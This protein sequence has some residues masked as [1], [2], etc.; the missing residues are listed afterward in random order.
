M[1]K[2][3]NTF[4]GLTK[5]TF[6]LAFTS[7]FADIAT[8]MLYPVLPVFLTQTLGANAEIVGLVEGVATATQNIVQ[9]FSGWLADRIQNRK[10]VAL[11]GYTLAALSKPV[12]G[13]ATAWQMVLFTRFSDRF[14]TGM[15]S[16]PRDALIAS[17][18]DANHRGKAFGLEGIGD[19]LGAF[20]GP[21]LAVVLLYTFHVNLR[22]IFFIAFIPG[23][24]AVSMILSV[25][26]KKITR[27]EGTAVKLT[28]KH[29]PVNYWKYIGVTA[30]F[31]L[32]NTSTSFLILQTRNLGIPLFETILIYAFFNL[33]AALIS[34]PAGSLSDK[35]GR[36]TILLGSFVIFL[37]TFLGFAVSKNVLVIGFLFVLYGMYQGI[38][39]ATGKALATDLVPQGLRASGIGWYATT[40]GIAS[41]IASIIGGQLWVL[42]NPHATFLYGAIFAILGIFGLLFFIH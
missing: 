41:L 28:L 24:F 12:F 1:N 22:T 25:N 42:I 32:G 14:G 38:F 4:A 27:D 39:R 31:G 10:T 5:N 26:E 33:V 30:L 36:K 6:L 29:F 15:R 8:E 37:I 2:R 3:K 9:G 16:A 35:F 7:F 19:N 40:I 34:Y 23:L 17:S 11:I 18:A 20:V 13:F 21:L